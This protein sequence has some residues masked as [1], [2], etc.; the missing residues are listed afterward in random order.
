MDKPTQRR[1]QGAR[2]WD[3]LSNA[4]ALLQ[5]HQQSVVAE[6]LY[7]QGHHVELV[8]CLLH[9]NL[10]QLAFI[11]EQPMHSPVESK[12][13]L[14]LMY[15]I[16][17][18]FYHFILKL[19]LTLEALF[20]AGVVKDVS[21]TYT[22]VCSHTHTCACV[23]VISTTEHEEI[24]LFCT[25]EYF[26]QHSHV[27]GTSQNEV[28]WVYTMKEHVTQSN[29]V[30]H[31]FHGFWK[32]VQLCDSEQWLTSFSCV[33][34]IKLKWKTMCEGPK[35]FVVCPVLCCRYHS[36]PSVKHHVTLA[37]PRGEILITHWP[38]VM[39]TFDLLW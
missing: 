33:P 16:D 7:F 10:E 39:L 36:P 34:W 1:G 28:Q 35:A 38:S 8:C 25:S 14:Q 30:A 22:H 13:M 15:F 4:R 6:M 31:W 23:C 3:A 21:S 11:R 29:R 18:P 19:K 37:T 20:K 27:C 5:S 12:A 17:S 24:M 9:R 26:W 32:A 2:D